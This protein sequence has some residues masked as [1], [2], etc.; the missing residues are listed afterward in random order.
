[1]SEL[2]TLARA[3]A[4]SP[5]DAA[6]RLVYADALEEAG[7]AEAAAA[8]RQAVLDHARELGA[9]DG[10]QLAL[11]SDEVGSYTRDSRLLG[12]WDDGL[13]HAVGMR[14]VK[15]LFGFDADGTADDDPYLQACL[16]AYNDGAQAG[17]DAHEEAR[18]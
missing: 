4:T 5:A 10:A 12:A 16:A 9:E 14:D 8:Q 3:V 17:W 13:I 2:D 1:M 11:E 15:R 6:A 18:P 7:Q